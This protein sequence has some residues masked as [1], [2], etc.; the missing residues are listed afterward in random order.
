MLKNKKLNIFGSF[1]RNILIIN[2]INTMTSQLQSSALDLILLNYS[3]DEETVDLEV[4][5]VETLRG[6]DMLTETDLNPNAIEWKPKSLFV[7]SHQNRRG[8]LRQTWKRRLKYLESY[9]FENQ[10]Q[11]SIDDYLNSVLFTSKLEQIANVIAFKSVEKPNWNKLETKLLKGIFALMVKSTDDFW[12]L[13]IIGFNRPIS[14]YSRYH[15]IQ[16]LDEN[17]K[18]EEV[19]EEVDTCCICF[20][21][22]EKDI[23][24]IQLMC[25]HKLC[26]GCFLQSCKHK[27]N[28][29]ME[30]CPICRRSV[31]R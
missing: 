15:I 5:H 7:R 6:M 27:G 1:Y 11:K 25:K 29:V 4:L 9:K 23:P 31:I 28:Y 14:K 12:G 16:Y 18:P 13:N 24:T 21:N 19:E 22:M 26:T 8:K 10:F 20:E 17:W 3:S 30:S 2:F